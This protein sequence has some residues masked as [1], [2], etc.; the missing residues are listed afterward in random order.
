MIW[1]IMCILEQVT[2]LTFKSFPYY[3]NQTVAGYIFVLNND[4]FESDEK[5]SFQNVRF[6]G[7]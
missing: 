7:L 6:Y 1:S 5:S 4:G 3:Q 2:V